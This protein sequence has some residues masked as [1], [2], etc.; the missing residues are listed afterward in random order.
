[1]WISTWPVVKVSEYFLSFFFNL[2]ESSVWW[3]L[4]SHLI[5]VGGG[6]VRAG[7]LLLWDHHKGKSLRFRSR[8][9]AVLSQQSRSYV[10]SQIWPVSSECD[11]KLCKRLTK[12]SVVL[13]DDAK[14]ISFQNLNSSTKLWDRRQVSKSSRKD[15]RE[16]RKLEMYFYKWNTK[17][18]SL[19]NAMNFSVLMNIYTFCV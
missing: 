4:N 16:E 13:N 14:M 17:K 19:C 9:R 6:T 18:E 7:R 5:R 11:E 10:P 8:R 15:W 3:F 2:L 12:T 1:M